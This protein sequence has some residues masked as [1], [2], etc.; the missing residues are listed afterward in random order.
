MPL[1]WAQLYAPFSAG[2]TVNPDCN[3]SAAIS[4]GIS[5]AQALIVP[6]QD[7]SSSTSESLTNL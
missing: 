2:V 6:D 1:L 3:I 5:S 4:P 7:Y